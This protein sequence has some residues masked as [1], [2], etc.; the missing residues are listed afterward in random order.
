[1]KIL[2]GTGKLTIFLLAALFTLYFISCSDNSVTTSNQTDDQYLQE[3]VNSG[4]SSSADD[5][6]NLMFNETTDLDDGGPVGGPNDNPIDSLVMW[7]R[8]ILNV[9]V[10]VQITSEGDSL[11]NVTVT[12][13]ITGELHIVYRNNGQLTTVIKPYTESTKRKAV[14]K[15][16]AHTEHPRYNW[17]LYKVGI[18]DGRTE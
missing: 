13:L 11:K 4:Y 17:R 10:N 16:I 7:G 5:D 9:N 3:I 14:F 12:R 2:N 18:L 1:M 15:R 6:D 8:K